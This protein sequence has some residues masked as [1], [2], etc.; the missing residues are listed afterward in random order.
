MRYVIA[1]VCLPTLAAAAPPKLV[2]V[3]VAKEPIAREVDG[4][5]VV[6]ESGE[7]GELRRHG[8]RRADR[9]R[10]RSAELAS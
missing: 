5:I 10:D 1:F 9:D 8:H 6:P 3:D 2:P 7:R 4:R